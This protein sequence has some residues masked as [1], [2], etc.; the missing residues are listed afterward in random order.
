MQCVLARLTYFGLMWALSSLRGLYPQ[1]WPEMMRRHDSQRYIDAADQEIK[2]L[3][4]L[5]TLEIVD[6]APDGETVYSTRMLWKDK[7][8]LNGAPARCKGRLV[9]R[10]FKNDVNAN[11]F[12]PVCRIEAIRHLMSMV[13][14]HPEWKIHH[15]DICNAFCTAKLDKPIYIHMPRCMVEEDPTLKNKKIRVVRALYGHQGESRCVQ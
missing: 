9:V 13:P 1:S 7:P 4:A 15:V 5:D 12:A 8:A 14:E 10:N 11:V 3:K 2:D 6:K